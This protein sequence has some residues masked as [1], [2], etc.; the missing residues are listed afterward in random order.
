MKDVHNSGLKY[1]GRGQWNYDAQ[2]DSEIPSLEY[3]KDVIS[4]NYRT[5]LKDPDL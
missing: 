3:E 1:E 2:N 4:N 5:H